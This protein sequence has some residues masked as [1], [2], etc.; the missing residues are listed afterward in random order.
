MFMEIRQLLLQ[1]IDH[2][3]FNHFMEIIELIQVML[4]VTILWKLKS[5]NKLIMLILTILWK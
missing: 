1:Y 3:V 2:V 4:I 5:S